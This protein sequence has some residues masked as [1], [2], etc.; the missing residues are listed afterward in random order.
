MIR[1]TNNGRPR[2]EACQSKC[3]ECLPFYI[4]DSSISRGR[5]HRHVT[6]RIHSDQRFP[7]IDDTFPKLIRTSP[8]GDDIPPNPQATPRHPPPFPSRNL[9]HSTLILH[10]EVVVETPRVDRGVLR[11][12]LTDPLSRGKEPSVHFEALLLE[13]C[14]ESLG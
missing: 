12:V 11:D 5:Q 7:S 13:S 2:H 8:P 1:A 3:K 9:P 14:A 10:R 6:L 4:N